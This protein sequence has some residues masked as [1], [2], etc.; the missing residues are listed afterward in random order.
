[1]AVFLEE[2]S[3]FRITPY[4]ALSAAKGLRRFAAGFFTPFG[5]SE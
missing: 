5:R 2:V 3:K 4:V 1:M